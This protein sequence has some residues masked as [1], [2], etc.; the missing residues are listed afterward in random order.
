[1]FQPVDK[2]PT[3]VYQVKG[4]RLVVAIQRSPEE[5]VGALNR[6]SEYLR[7]ILAMEARGEKP[8]S[9]MYDPTVSTPTEAL[10]ERVKQSKRTS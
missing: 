2:E 3:R 1:M 10:A 6:G 9:I 7:R 5:A 8:T 4:R